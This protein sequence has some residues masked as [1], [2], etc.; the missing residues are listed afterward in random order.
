M[1]SNEK[2][3]HLPDVII[4]E[5]SKKDIPTTNGS[6]P[7]Y[8]TIDKDSEANVQN[9]N[10]DVSK[11]WRRWCRIEPLMVLLYVATNS[12]AISYPQLLYDMVRTN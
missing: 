5:R 3:N 1:E 7:H 9:E 12:I 6:A 10:T 2:K 8:G 11:S 4:E